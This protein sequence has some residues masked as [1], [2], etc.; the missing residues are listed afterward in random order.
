MSANTWDSPRQARKTGHPISAPCVPTRRPEGTRSNCRS[1]GGGGGNQGDRT[2]TVA[3]RCCPPTATL[4][5][6]AQGLHLPLGSPLAIRT[7]KLRAQKP[8][9]EG[10]MAR[11]WAPTRA[12]KN[13][14]LIPPGIAGGQISPLR[15]LH[16]G[17]LGTQSSQSSANRNER[18]RL[19]L[20]DGNIGMESIQ[21]L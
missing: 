10:H 4:K 19:P 20:W 17:L 12:D 1:L 3:E 14:V 7:W 16:G 5:E 15:R 8:T 2:G 21:A 6:G 9:D 13:G 18:D 11:S